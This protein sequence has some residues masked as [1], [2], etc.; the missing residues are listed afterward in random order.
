MLL[1]CSLPF[2]VGAFTIGEATH[3]THNQGNS[4]KKNG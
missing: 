4:G 1:I 2:K 3:D